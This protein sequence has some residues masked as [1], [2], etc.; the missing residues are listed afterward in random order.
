V[1]NT[2]ELNYKEGSGWI[3]PY[4]AFELTGTLSASYNC[5]TANYD[6]VLSWPNLAVTINKGLAQNT[7][8]QSFIL[9]GWWFIW[10]VD[11]L[12]CKR[13]VCKQIGQLIVDTRT[14]SIQKKLCL[15]LSGS[16]CT[17]WDR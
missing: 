1:A 2:I 17:E 7:N 9:S 13:S 15:T 16:E 14:Q 8:F 12:Q 10:S 3:L 6:I 11:V 5:Q 4:N